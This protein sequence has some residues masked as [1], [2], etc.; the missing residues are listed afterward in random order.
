MTR[1]IF[2]LLLTLTLLPLVW[3]S[4]SGIVLLQV[5]KTNRR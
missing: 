1:I 2:N 3:L 4:A 5:Y